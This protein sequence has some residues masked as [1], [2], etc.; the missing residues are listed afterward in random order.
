MNA[1]GLPGY[2]LRRLGPAFSQQAQARYPALEF[3]VATLPELAGVAA[4]TFANVLCETVIMHLPAER[5]APSVERLIA[6]L[7]P[8]GVLYLSWRVTEGA[9]LRDGNGRLYAAFDADLVRQR[10]SGAKLLLDEEV[11]S[12]SS[13]KTIHRVV[14][15]NGG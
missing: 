9:S 12:A 5:I 11:V 3:H 15:R 1:N 10:L 6:L 13:G 8:N 7:R 14:A 4:G 2:R